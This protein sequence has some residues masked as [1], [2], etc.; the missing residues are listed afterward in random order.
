MKPGTVQIPIPPFH[1][2]LKLFLTQDTNM[3]S[4]QQVM[5]LNPPPEMITYQ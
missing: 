3:M 5:A 2:A 4:P 1:P